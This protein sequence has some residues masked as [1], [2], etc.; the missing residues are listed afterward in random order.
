[1]KTSITAR[2]HLGPFEISGDMCTISKGDEQVKLTPK[3]MDVLLYLAENADRVISATELLDQ[4]WSPVTSDHAVHKAIADLRHA[5]GDNVR[6]QN[7]IKT[8][9]KRGYKLLCTPM[10]SKNEAK[11]S[12]R[13]VGFVT[14]LRQSVHMS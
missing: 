3:N 4:F 8:L 14:N 9:P 1:M 13:F 11:Q 5:M 7:Y 6:C 12:N 2:F 10:S